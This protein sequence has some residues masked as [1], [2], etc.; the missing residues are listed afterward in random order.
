MVI[1]DL[2]KALLSGKYNL[3]ETAVCITQT[4]GQCRATNYVPILKKAIVDA[5]ITTVPVISTAFSGGLFNEQPGFKLNLRKLIMPAFNGILF[6]DA[7]AN[8]Y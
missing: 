1:G 3:N 5:G 8:M 6:G 4:G 2:V 7:I